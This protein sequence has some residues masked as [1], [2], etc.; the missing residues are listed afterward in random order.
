MAHDR[1][2][3][4][5]AIDQLAIQRLLAEYADLVNCRQWPGLARLFLADAPIELM[6]LGRGPLELRGPEALGRFIGEVVERFDFFQFVQLNARLELR[7]GE[8]TALGRIF[9]CE[10][11]WEKAAGRWAQVFGVYHDTYRRVEGRWWFARR[12]FAPLVSAGSEGA[13]ADFQ[14]PLPPFLAGD[15]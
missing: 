5:Q 2:A 4:D 12:T 6:T 8:D 9:V 3:L 1:D 13:I 14:S 15:G 7:P 11:R 10:F